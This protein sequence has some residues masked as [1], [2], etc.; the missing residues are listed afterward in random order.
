VRRGG[1]HPFRTGDEVNLLKK[2]LVP[3]FY[4]THKIYTIG[5]L[6][7]YKEI[8]NFWLNKILKLSSI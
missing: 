2:L 3:M 6:N 7:K 4:A 8:V 5:M 1:A